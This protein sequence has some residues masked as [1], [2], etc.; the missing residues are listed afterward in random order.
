MTPAASVSLDSVNGVVAVIDVGVAA[1]LSP[2]AKAAHAKLR[3]A[4]ILSRAIIPR[5]PLW[6][7]ND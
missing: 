1:L 7:T 2:T 4:E 3:S 6:S 5:V